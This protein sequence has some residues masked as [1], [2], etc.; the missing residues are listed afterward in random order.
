MTTTFD[1]LK[2][3]TLSAARDGGSTARSVDAPRA[4]RVR[5]PIREALR[6]AVLT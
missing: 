4:P 6:G 5:L 1:T 2:A 3:T